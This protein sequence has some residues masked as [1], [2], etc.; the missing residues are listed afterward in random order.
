V[1]ST[2]RV[3]EVNILGLNENLLSGLPETEEQEPKNF[4]DP[5]GVSRTQAAMREL[6]VERSAVLGRGEEFLSDFCDR[7]AGRYPLIVAVNRVSATLAK[8][9]LGSERRVQHAGHA[10]AS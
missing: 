4:R 3:V 5:I 8:V 2:Q 9:V 1:R 7:C 6:M 10:P